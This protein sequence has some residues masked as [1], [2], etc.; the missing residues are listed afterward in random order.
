MAILKRHGIR[1]HLTGGVASVAY[2]EPRM[3][4]DV[5]LVIDNQATL[6]SLSGIL[7][8][9]AESDF[10]YD[11]DEVRN[12]VQSLGMFQLMDREE[13]L[14]L[15]VYAREM[16]PGELGRSQPAEIF[17]GVVLPIASRADAALSK[18]IWVSKGSHKSRKD[19]RSIFRRTDDAEREFIRSFATDCGISGLMA[20]VLA[21]SDELS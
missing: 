16:I 5:D 2:G 21:E 15:D 11:G 19:F 12:S 10:L 3:T 6:D 18:L 20:E 14:K 1:F 7:A 13:C 9:L 4:Q 8:S 17:A